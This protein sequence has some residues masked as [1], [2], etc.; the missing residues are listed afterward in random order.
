MPYKK[1]EPVSERKMTKTRYEGHNT[2][3]QLL[4]DIYRISD[5]EDIKLKTRI[6]MAM[7][8]KMHEKLKEYR[9]G[10]TIN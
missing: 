6:A 8:K 3:C 2:I 9:D 10:N 4:R 1:V 7:A 5:N